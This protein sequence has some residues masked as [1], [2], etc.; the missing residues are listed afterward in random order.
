[1]V[2]EG[3]GTERVMCVGAREGR[4]TN[5]GG[6]RLR[7]G[8]GEGS[9]KR[10]GGGE[11][12]T[13][14]A[15][16]PPP[17]PPRPPAP[18][19]LALPCAAALSRVHAWRMC[20]VGSAGVARRRSRP[21]CLQSGVHSPPAPLQPP[22]PSPPRPTT[23]A[24]SGAAK[25]DARTCVW[26]GGGGATSKQREGET[27]KECDPPLRNKQKTERAERGP[28]SLSHPS[29]AARAPHGNTTSSAGDRAKVRAADARGS[30]PPDL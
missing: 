22:P 10:G 8:E 23:P 6:E 24:L 18:P 25:L 27:K 16:P 17:P 12:K 1:M 15:P 20:A 3:E 13:R 4:E 11:E 2:K 29:P 7:G 30:P 5:D 14:A 19:A 26:F 28:A 9:V 21:A